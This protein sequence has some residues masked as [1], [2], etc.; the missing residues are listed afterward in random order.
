MTLASLYAD[1]L[2]L[3]AFG[4]VCR[5]TAS[6]LRILGG[7][8]RHF[9]WCSGG[10]SL[11]FQIPGL[12]REGQLTVII[13]P[14]ISLMQDQARSARGDSTRIQTH[15]RARTYATSPPPPSPFTRTWSIAVVHQTVGCDPVDSLLKTCLYVTLILLRP[16]LPM[17][18]RP[19]SP[20]PFRPPLAQVSALR[21]L[22]LRAEL[23][24]ADVTDRAEAAR[25][26]QAN[27][28]AR[29]EY[30]DGDGDYDGDGDGD[31]D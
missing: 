9:S 18:R 2:L 7:S 19:P 24:A 1:F 3:I 21:R 26:Q 14:L 25:V 11:C 31:G 5:F 23:L 20:T 22:S 12:L 29:D 17:P 13:S 10:K 16:P 30:G 8:V 27:D 4:R 28:G 6:R 15:A